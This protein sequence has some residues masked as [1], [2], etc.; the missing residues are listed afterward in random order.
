MADNPFDLTGKVA[1]VTGSTQGIG[2]GM[3]VALARAG[4]TVAINGRDPAKTEAA[5]AEI[6]KAG[7]SAVACP[8]DATDAGSIDAAVTA[9]EAKTGAIDILVNNA[10]HNI[11]GDL[12]DYTMEDFHK[13]MALNV[14]GVLMV[15]QRVARGMIERKR[16][17][18]V[19]TA[20]MSAEFARPGGGVYST[21]KA[22]VQMLG[23]SMAVEWGRHNI[24][25]N[26]ISP[27]WNKTEL[28]IR[29]LAD[30]PAL[31]SWVN[32]RTPLGR[33][34]DPAV[35]LGGAI[36]FFASPASDFVTGQTLLVDGG[37]ASTF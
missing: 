24:Q 27:G 19:I 31:E 29:I 21:S 26:V 7:L 25:V 14:D 30:N 5:A 11:R 18:V 8:F 35:D 23:K 22:A 32:D 13:L 3:A 17:K 4:A 33:W 20:S 37:F 15:S 6:R 10:G 36:V 1:L 34:S 28:M 9:L 16:G 2:N 12:V